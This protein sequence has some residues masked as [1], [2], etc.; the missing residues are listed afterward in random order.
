MYK[1]MGMY[2]M[3]ENGIFRISYMKTWVHISHM[4]IEFSV[5]HV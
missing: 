2:F 1:K 5:F 3:G 4:K